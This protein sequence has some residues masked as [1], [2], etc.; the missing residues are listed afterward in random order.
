[1][2][3]TRTI[4]LFVLNFI[5]ILGLQ[6]GCAT[7]K[8]TELK[9]GNAAS[10]AQHEQKSGVAIGL[11]PMIEAKEIKE[12]FRINLLEKGLLP[13]L[14][15]AENQS[16]S[17]S[18]ILSKDK[19]LVLNEAT[20]ATNTSQRA[21]VASGTAGTAVGITGASMLA[22]TSLAGAPLLLAG[23]KMASDATVIQHNLADKEF[24]SRT[25]GPGQKAQGFIYFQYPKKTPPS[26]VHQ[27]LVE[28]KDLSTGQPI[29]FRFTV[30]L[31][32]PKL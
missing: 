20:S 9:A 22:A 19:V 12:T 25:L 8:V 10:Y 7:M 11:H 31:T 18:F 26:G 14:L 13:I 15:V 16:E 17:S 1:M 24:Y 28:L 27:V 6:T 5:G 23:L 2:K 21:N 29:T 3:H 32:V 4:T 30:D